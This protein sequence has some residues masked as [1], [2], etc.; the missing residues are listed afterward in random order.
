MQAEEEKRRADEAERLKNEAIVARQ[1]AEMQRGA[2]VAAQEE[3][4][5][6]R[7]SAEKAKR[8]ATGFAWGAGQ[9]AL[10]ALIAFVYA[11]NQSEMAWTN[12]KIAREAKTQAD[13][14]ARQA[15]IQKDY[16]VQAQMKA[17][18]SSQVALSEKQRADKALAEARGNAKIAVASLLDMAK[19]AVEQFDYEEAQQWIDAAI[20]LDENR[21]EVG[22]ALLEQAYVYNHTGQWKTARKRTAQAARL[23]GQNILA[24]QAEN[25]TE[26]TALKILQ[27]LQQKISE[28][29]FKYLQ[30]L[31]FPENAA[32]LPDGSFRMGS[33]KDSSEMPVHNQAVSAFQLARTETT[34]MQYHLFCLAKGRTLDQRMSAL[35]T[36]VNW[37][38]PSWGW[39]YD[40]PIVNVSWYDAI[41]YANWASEQQGYKKVYSIEI[42]S[43]GIRKVNFDPIAN[44][45]R[46]PT[47]A[48]WEYAARAGENYEY[49]GSNQIEDVAWYVGN[50][51]SHANPVKRKKANKAG[52]FDLSGNVLEW[53]WDWFG[54]YKAQPMVDY[55]GPE[56]GSERV[57]RSGSW[58]DTPGYC[59]VALRNFGSPGVRTDDYGFRLG[60]NK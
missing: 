57:L 42:N 37:N 39:Q 31:Y 26:M 28:E 13:S 52:L 25:T 4:E 22:N 34:V 54:D 48:E 3:S 47:E 58:S 23:L 40:R 24:L 35:D 17:D 45:Y 41:E 43:E 1:E 8:R 30:N 16:A 10:A 60:R 29:Q 53:C 11:H 20:R 36:F 44:G 56:F 59:R 46:L 12:A 51:G 2:A 33:K 38:T 55:K 27:A 49:S 15:R 19:K 9:L 21:T 14:N 7:I 18:S 32:V 5:N 50:S 6:Q